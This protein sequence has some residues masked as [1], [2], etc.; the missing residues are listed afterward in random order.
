MN[1][2][3]LP[4]ESIR[5]QSSALARL[6]LFRQI[7]SLPSG[8]GRGIYA[9]GSMEAG[10]AWPVGIRPAWDDL[11]PAAALFVGADS[12]FGPFFLGYG[13]S[14]T[15]DGSFYLFLGRPF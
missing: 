5:G 10:N 13:R 6:V 3:G 9:G 12:V 15:G 1:L 14:D 4:P 8:L 2:S 7:G 11:R